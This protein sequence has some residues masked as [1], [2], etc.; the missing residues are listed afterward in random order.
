MT[1]S[2]KSGAVG[3]DHSCPAAGFQQSHDQS[4]EQVGRLAG[5]EV[6]GEVALDAVFLAAAKGRVGEDDIDAVGWL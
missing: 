1:P 2:P 5:S 4:E 3:Q 6:L